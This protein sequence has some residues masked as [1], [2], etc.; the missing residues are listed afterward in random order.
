MRRLRQISSV[1]HWDQSANSSR[2]LDGCFIF[3]CNYAKKMARASTFP[4]NWRK[5][6]VAIFAESFVDRSSR[7]FL[8]KCHWYIRL[9]IGSVIDR[10]ARCSE[11]KDLIDPF[12]EFGDSRVNSRLIWLGA[13]D[14]PAYDSSEDPPF[15]SRPLDHHWAAAVTL[16]IINRHRFIICSLMIKA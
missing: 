11:Q 15:V 5:F 3:L 16:L 6:R 4:Y 2:S 9:R 10:G 14:S 7:L 12:S 13:T 1:Y 8:F